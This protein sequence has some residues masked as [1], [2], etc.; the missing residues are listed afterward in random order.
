MLIWVVAGLNVFQ[1]YDLR[2]LP[3]NK[4]AAN[5]Y[6]KFIEP[7]PEPPPE[8]ATGS[9]AGSLGVGST[10]VG[11][12]GVGATGVGAGPPFTATVV[13]WKLLVTPP[14]LTCVVVFVLF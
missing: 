10:G 14:I 11:A 13:V 1:F 4:P 2:F 8:L 12:T 7:P 9:V 6:R 5:R 3:K